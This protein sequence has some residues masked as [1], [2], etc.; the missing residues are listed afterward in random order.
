MTKPPATILIVDD[1]IQNRKLLETLLRPEG[2]IT[3]SAANGEE[4]LTAIA[5]QLPDLILLDIMMPGI[6]GYQLASILKAAPATSR[7]PII[8]ITALVDR[9]AR[10][11]A[12]KAGAEEFLTKPVD[13]AELWL[14]V[15][16]LLRLKA[17]GDLQNHSSQLEQQVQARTE[18]IMSLNAGLEERVRQRTAQLRTA[19]KEL[20]AFSYSLSHDLRTPLSAIDGFSDL[21]GSEISRGATTDRGKHYLARIRAGVAY[22]SQLIDAMLLLAHVSRTSPRWVAVDLSA[23]AQMVLAGYQERE[24]ER[25]AHWDIQPGM[26]AQ[27]DPQLLQQVLENLLGN[28]WKFCGRQQQ[29]RI[30]FS[31]E[32]G[33]DGKDVYAVRDNGA[34]FDMSYSDKLFGTFQRLHGAA[35]FPGTGIGLA[36]VNRIIARHGGKVWA[37]SVEGQGANFYFTLGN[38]DEAAL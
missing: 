31:S 27:G 15:R 18:E 29:T 30:S 8:M 25:V 16:N 32:R 21:L 34:G 35:E 11:A 37:D 1:E 22:M 4:A 28:A 17:Y 23:V 14:R 13:R 33:A 36:T 5:Q 10:L 26:S 12:L 9:D 24:P 20:E 19:N 7:I 38:E 6:D 2:Y 3:K